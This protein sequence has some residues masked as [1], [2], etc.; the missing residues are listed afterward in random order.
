MDWVNFLSKKFNMRTGGYFQNENSVRVLVVERRSPSWA[1]QI[2]NSF[3]CR[4]PPIWPKRKQ[5]SE[6]TFLVRHFDKGEIEWWPD[7]YPGVEAGAAKEKEKRGETPYFV[8]LSNVDKLGQSVY[9]NNSTVQNEH[10]Q[11]RKNKYCKPY[12]IV[13]FA[14][15][16]VFAAFGLWTLMHKGPMIPCTLPFSYFTLFPQHSAERFKVS[17]IHLI[18]LV[19]PIWSLWEKVD[20]LG[21]RLRKFPLQRFYTLQNDWESHYGIKGLITLMSK[22]I[23]S[24]NDCREIGKMQQNVLSRI[25]LPGVVTS[26]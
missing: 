14:T 4:R 1:P 24:T 22:Q 23:M 20:V 7:R 18:S 3:S 17:K 16:R 21:L 10:N 13:F 19:F 12:W 25:F 5:M 15:T 6:L 26:A 2:G 8:V 11:K 9:K